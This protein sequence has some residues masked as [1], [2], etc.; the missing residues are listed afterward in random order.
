[1]VHG[2]QHGLAGCALHLR[3][4]EDGGVVHQVVHGAG[5]AAKQLANRHADLVEPHR[6][7]TVLGHGV[8]LRRGDAGGAGI[9]ED[10][11]QITRAAAR[12][13]QPKGHEHPARHREVV[14]KVLG[15]GQHDVVAVTLARHGNPRF[16]PDA[17]RFGHGVTQDQLA[18]SHQVEQCPLRRAGVLVNHEGRHHR[19]EH[20]HGRD[21]LADLLQQQAEVRQG[22]ALAANIFRQAQR[23]PAQVDKLRPQLRGMADVACFRQP[24]R[25]RRAF[26][27]QKLCD[28]LLDFKFLRVGQYIHSCLRCLTGSG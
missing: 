17:G 25:G 21:D 9:D 19:P 14:N 16:A 20:R 6:V 8:Q 1:M 23:Q 5:A 7:F 26:A 24:H 15:A 2:Q 11:R 3:H 28:G 4:R 12:I 27:H 18:R 10:G 22:Q 13:H